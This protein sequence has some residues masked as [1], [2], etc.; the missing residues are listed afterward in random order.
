LP[1]QF[2]QDAARGF[3]ELVA[4]DAGSIAADREIEHCDLQCS[5]MEA[6]WNAITTKSDC[7]EEGS[8]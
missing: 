1:P 8:K 3:D 2:Q 7:S 4:F 6:T 5:A